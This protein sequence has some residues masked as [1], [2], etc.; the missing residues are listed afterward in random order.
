MAVVT[1]E[2]IQG[3]MTWYECG[4]SKRATDE[5]TTYEYFDDTE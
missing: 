2:M 1:A 3:L 5:C 4:T